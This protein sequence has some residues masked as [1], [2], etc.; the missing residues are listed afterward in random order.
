MATATDLRQGIADLS[1]LA[2]ADL[3]VLWRE[4]TTPDLARQAL[5]DVLPALCETYGLAAGTLAADWYDELR[6]QASVAGRFT[7]IV[8]EIEDQG[9]EVLARWG[10][11][12]LFKAEPDFAAAQTL[13]QGGLQRRIANVSR[14]TVTTS[15]YQDPSTVG[16]QRIGTGSCAFCRMLIARGDVYDIDTA[17]FASH[18]HC[19]CQAMPAFQGEPLPVKPYMPSSK[20]ISDAD[21]ARV[22][23]YLRENEI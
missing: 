8:A 20:T 3:A 14:A 22:R 1:T 11:A 17:Q 7:A 23:A 19:N 6:E 4:A 2:N 10:I 12:P 9:A 5:L 18:D 15:T 16:W 21:R 13:I